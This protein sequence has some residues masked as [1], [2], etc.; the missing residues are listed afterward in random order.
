VNPSNVSRSFDRLRRAA[1]V[2][3]IRVHDL[4]H[5]AASLLL[6]EGVSVKEVQERVGHAN[7]RIT[8]DI[9]AHLLA[10]AHDSAATAMSRI[11]AAGSTATT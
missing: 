10:D 6:M 2:P 3:Q 11:L 5:T 8:L 4:R 1:G 9:Y 7:I